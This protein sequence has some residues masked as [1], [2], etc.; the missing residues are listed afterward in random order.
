MR[1]VPPLMSNPTTQ[2]YNLNT[3]VPPVKRKAG[4]WPLLKE[5]IRNGGPGYLQFA[6]TNVCNA[7]CDF[8]G[9]SVDRFDPKTRKSV[10]LQEAY[11][12]IDISVKN[13]IGFL[14]FVGGEPMAHKDL[15]SMLKY[16]ADSGIQPMICTNGSL[17]TDENVRMYAQLGLAS[18][19][20]SID[21]ASVELHEKNR[22]LKGVCEKIARANKL[23]RELGVESVASITASRLI[24]DYTKLP[25]F[26]TS[27][28]FDRCTFSYPISVR[29][30]LES[31]Y[32]SFSDSNLVDYTVEELIEVFQKLQALKESREITIVNPLESLKEMVRHLRKEPEVFPCLGGSKYFYLDWNL[33]LYRC[34]Y[35]HSPMCKIYDFD[36]SKLIRDHC[37][38][39]MIDCYRDPSI[40]QF[41][42]LNM[43]DI[44]HDFKSLR[45]GKAAGKVF[46]RRNLTSL[47]AVLEGQS[48]IREWIKYT[49]KKPG[50]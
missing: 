27:L 26:L 14:L 12:T 33:D 32:L 38:V 30:P 4:F 25:P 19:I 23:F 50:Q 40:L 10:T 6:I 47:K 36:S 42:A 7:H 44:F 21:A 43:S 2:D 31:S 1:K 18:V 35:W 24:D 39:C 15:P 22:G 41:I 28:G 29:D 13:G 34:H 45:W 5:C 46:D 8:C 20:M 49:G 3:P 9:F 17:W 37:T 16:A 11:D 48:W